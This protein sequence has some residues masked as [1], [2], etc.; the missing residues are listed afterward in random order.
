MGM[1][2][3]ALL[4]GGRDDREIPP[5]PP[6]EPIAPPPASTPFSEALGAPTPEP[7]ATSEEGLFS[8]TLRTI[9]KPR[10]FVAKS[11]FSALEPGFEPTEDVVT[12][13]NIIHALSQKI[14][15]G[16]KKSASR[17]DPGS[18]KELEDIPESPIGK[19]ADFGVGLTVDVLTDPLTYTGIGTM[20]RAG[21]AAKGGVRGAELAKTW[22]EQAAAGQRAL[23]KFGGKTII[24]GEPVFKV[25]SKLSAIIGDTG[26]AKETA[27]WMHRVFNTTIGLPDTKKALVEF[28]K[29]SQ[30]E[31]RHF[32]VMVAANAGKRESE[33]N[34]L[35]AR[36]G[37]ETPEF[38]RQVLSLVDAPKEEVRNLRSLLDSGTLS[39][40][41]ADAARLALGIAEEGAALFQARATAGAPLA[42]LR[43]EAFERGM[44]N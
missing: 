25:V 1:F 9:D 18:Y 29:A 32:L 34:R 8:K 20:T 3:D 40:D 37:Y 30:S 6:R 10:A 35:A 17:S 12:G 16:P 4:G 39:P 5:V 13:S 41:E 28:G 7:E 42:D 36:L 2:S 38:R 26:A 43:R 22:A 11:I 21:L 33:I 19:L 24:R 15:T 44:K 23:V 27:Q 14:V 31:Q